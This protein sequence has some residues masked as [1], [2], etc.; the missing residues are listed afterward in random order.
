LTRYPPTQPPC[1]SGI[2]PPVPIIESIRVDRF[3]S[4][5]AR[6]PKTTPEKHRATTPSERILTFQAR[7]AQVCASVQLWSGSR[8][9]DHERI[10]GCGSI[11]WQGLATGCIV[12][13]ETTTVVP[14]TPS[15]HAANSRSTHPSGQHAA[16]PIAGRYS[17][18]SGHHANRRRRPTEQ[19]AQAFL[20]YSTLRSRDGMAI[21]IDT[22]CPI[23]QKRRVQ[24]ARLDRT[25]YQARCR[26]TDHAITPVLTALRPGRS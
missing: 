26:R 7:R 3:C 10:S 25:R 13:N 24:T 19:T 20:R 16:N 2:P 9:N 18:R 22:G 1:H 17:K 21:F 12:L 11:L 15:R 4:R 23:L 5:P 14:E 6:N 8:P